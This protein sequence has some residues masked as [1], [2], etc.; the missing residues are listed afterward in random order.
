MRGPRVDPGRLEGR[1]SRLGLERGSGGPRFLR[2]DILGEGFWA[3]GADVD[4]ARVVG[5]CLGVFLAVETELALP[6][7]QVGLT[8][9]ATAVTGPVEPLVVTR[10][11]LVVV[12]DDVGRPIEH[13]RGR[14]GGCAGAALHGD[15][16]ARANGEGGGADE[17]AGGAT[18]RWL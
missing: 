14:T 6:S 17:P 16:A 1:F 9:H 5:R 8:V 15:D 11:R 18:T 12:R 3:G 2:G 4:V 7:N 13:D 10:S